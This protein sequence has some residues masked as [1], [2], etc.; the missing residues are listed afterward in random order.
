MTKLMAI[1][2]SR[3]ETASRVERSRMLLAYQED[4]SF[5]AVGQPWGCII[6]RS[7]AVSSGPWRSAHWR[8][9]MIA[10]G[11]AKR[12]RSRPRPRHGW[13]RWPAGKPRISAIH[14]SCGRRAFLARHAREHGLAA[15]HHCLSNLAQG[16]VCKIL[17]AQ[18]IKPHKVR[19]YLERRDPEFEVKIAQILC[20][21]KEVEILRQPAPRRRKPSG[22]RAMIS[23]TRSLA[24]R[25]LARPRRTCRRNPAFMQLSPEIMSISATER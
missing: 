23:S 4:P 9:W 20:V 19:Y 8:R 10:P 1:A 2:R 22:R 21:Y 7:G 3:T 25:R 5:F 11:Q 24:C 15:G 14:M 13:C 18:A 16:T 17:G 6:R 12:R